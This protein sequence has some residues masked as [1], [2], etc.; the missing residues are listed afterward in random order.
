MGLGFSEIVTVLVVILL[1]FG[2]RKMP[3]LARA[4]GR[5][6]RE[7]RKAMRDLERTWE[8]AA[9]PEEGGAEERPAVAEGKAPEGPHEDGT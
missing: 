6:V 7:F 4:L 3:E 5:G 8:Q 2:P 1:V 9:G